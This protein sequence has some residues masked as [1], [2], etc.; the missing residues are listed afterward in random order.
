MKCNALSGVLDDFRACG[1]PAVKVWIC[2]DIVAVPVFA[3]RCSK[4]HHVN[5]MVYKEIGWEE[6]ALYEV[7]L[8]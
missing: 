7:M 5:S 1:K 6:F 2:E 3:L 8:G 4:H